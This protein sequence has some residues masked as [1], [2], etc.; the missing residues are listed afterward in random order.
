MQGPRR[1]NGWVEGPLRAWRPFDVAQDMLG[2]MKVGFPA[3]QF[4]ESIRR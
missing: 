2:G 1:K 3:F 4:F